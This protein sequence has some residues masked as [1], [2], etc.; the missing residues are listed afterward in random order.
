MS[1]MSISRILIRSVTTVKTLFTGSQ[2]PSW[3]RFCC[4]RHRYWQMINAASSAIDDGA[5]QENLVRG[6]I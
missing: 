1:P 4:Y 2:R 5:T 3:N 6:R